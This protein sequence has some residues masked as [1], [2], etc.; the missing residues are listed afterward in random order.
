MGWFSSS[1]SGSSATGSGEAVGLMARA[2]A[3]QKQ[4]DGMLSEVT[5]MSLP[6][7]KS[8]FECCVR[9]FDG[10][11]ENLDTIGE[12]VKQC[13]SRPEKFGNAVQSELNQ[14]QD[15]LMS[16]QKK[17]V[18]QF[19]SKAAGRSESISASMERCAVQCYDNNEGLLKDISSRLTSI[20]RNF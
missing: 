4:V 16:C 19:T 3:F 8:A 13:Q 9:C 6:L 5:R 1:D 2:E 10:G 20:Y 15:A 18:D 14:L 11:N 12:C 17:C 7:Q